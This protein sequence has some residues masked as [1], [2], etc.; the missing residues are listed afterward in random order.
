MNELNILLTDSIHDLNKLKMKIKGDFEFEQYEH[1]EI[2]IDDMDLERLAQCLKKVETINPNEEEVIYEKT[3]NILLLGQT[4][5]GKSTFIN[6][7]QNYMRHDD[8]SRD[9]SKI[10]N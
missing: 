7:F 3:L 5:C 4:G 2:Q 1:P 9:F 8:M 10:I 6:S